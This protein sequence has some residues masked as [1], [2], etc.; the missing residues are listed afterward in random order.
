MVTTAAPCTTWISRGSKVAQ[1]PADDDGA[2]RPC[3]SGTSRKAAPRRGAGFIGRA[4]TG[5]RQAGGL[6]HVH[7]EA[8][9]QE[10][11]SRPEPRPRRARWIVWSPPSTSSAKGMTA[12][13]P[14]C[15]A[16]RTRDRESASSRWRS[17]GVRPEAQKRAERRDQHRQR[18]H[19]RHEHRR[20]AEL[21]DH[22][23]VQRAQQH[24]R[25]HADRHL[26]QRQPQKLAQRQPS[27]RR[28]REGQEGVPSEVKRFR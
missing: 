9:H 24:D 25:R 20:H 2:T 18:D 17:D 28:V 14:I 22:H 3:R 26:E 19:D 21:H 13:P 1:Q 11:Q 16:S 15:Q 5:Q 10:G 12:S 27:R 23:A 7:A 6:R 4:V 8:R